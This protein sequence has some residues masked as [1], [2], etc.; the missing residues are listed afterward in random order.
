MILHEELGFDLFGRYAIIRDIIL[1][2]SN[3]DDLILDVGGRGNLLQKFLPN[4]KITYIDPY[5][6]SDDINF[7]KGDGCEMPFPESSYDWVVSADVFEHIP[8]IKRADYISEQHRVAKKGIILIAPFHSEQVSNAEKMVNNFHKTLYGSSHPWLIEHITNG[9]PNLDLTVKSLSK[10]IYPIDIYGNNILSI[11]NELLP[12]MLLYGKFE[13]ELPDNF[14]CFYNSRYNFDLYSDEETYRKILFVKLN[15]NLLSLDK[16][17]SADLSK[18][19]ISEKVKYI[20]LHI[21]NILTYEC[22]KRDEQIESNRIIIEQKDNYINELRITQIADKQILADKFAPLESELKLV[23]E[24]NEFLSE[25]LQ[26]Y[27][28]ENILYTRLENNNA[29]LQ[30]KNE[31][32]LKGKFILRHKILM[33]RNENQKL[34]S[35]IARQAEKNKL[36]FMQIDEIKQQIN[37]VIEKENTTKEECLLLR[38]ENSS[39]TRIYNEQRNELINQISLLKNLEESLRSKLV[40]IRNKYSNIHCKLKDTSHEV[41]TKLEIIKELKQNNLEKDKL[42][43]LCEIENN[44]LNT[45]MLSLQYD[46]KDLKSK[47]FVTLFHKEK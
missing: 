22:L 37:A 30:S 10:S 24:K 25:E 29:I 35:E 2:N 7:V 39:L 36:L 34:K 41:Q 21:R 11:W 19:E 20:S 33:L 46:L 6:D 18:N 3:T 26:R 4:H 5:V 27:I 8:Q 16:S 40:S 13:R 43:H 38:A 12:A 15:T 45:E 17:E 47:W 44:K 31:N 32:L 42:I 28:N 9:L 1:K 14:N 23:K